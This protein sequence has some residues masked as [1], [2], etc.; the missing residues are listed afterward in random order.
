MKISL[1][2]LCKE[3]NKRG[4]LR[5]GGDDSVRI[6]LTV[7]DEIVFEIKHERVT[8]AIPVIVEIMERPSRIVK[9]KVPLVTEPLVGPNWGTGYKCERY[10]EGK[11]KIGESDVFVNGFVYGTI[12]EVDLGKD[13][14]GEGEVGHFTNVEKKKVKIRIVDPAWLRGVS[15]DSLPSPSKKDSSGGE[16][17][18][19]EKAPEAVPSV[20]V[21]PPVAQASSVPTPVSEWKRDKAVILSIHKITDNTAHQV[22]E[23]CWKAIDPYGMLL[24]LHDSAGTSLILPSDGIRVDPSMMAKILDETLNI[25]NGEVKTEDI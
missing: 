23:A 20:S 13:T 25:G 18:K 16:S 24:H 6:L 7:H 17:P 11:T 10:H 8:E 14:P 21:A 2:T 1:V 3:F 22:R 4:W 9:W 12:R 15:S 19:E 5:N